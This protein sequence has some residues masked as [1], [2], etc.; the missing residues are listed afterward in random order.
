MA[1]KKT[2]NPRK[3]FVAVWCTEEE[4][5]Q[6]QKKAAMCGTKTGPYIRSLALEYPLNSKVDQYAVDQLLRAR[7]DLGRLGGLFKLWL[8]NNR[9]TQDA[10]LGDREYKDVESIIKEIEQ[11]EKKLIDIAKKIMKT[12]E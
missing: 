4:K 8:T 7:A 5:E 6:I 11:N 1:R 12:G 2:D 10:K 3:Q 9:D